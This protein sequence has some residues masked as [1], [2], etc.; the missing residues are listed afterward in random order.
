MSLFVHYLEH[1]VPIWWHMGDFVAAN[2][3]LQAEFVWPHF[4]AIQ[5]WLIVLLFVY[6][7]LR[8]M[9]RVIGRERFVAMFFRGPGYR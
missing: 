2:R 1:L 8:E 5:L 9:V 4:L 7:S 6:C 3:R